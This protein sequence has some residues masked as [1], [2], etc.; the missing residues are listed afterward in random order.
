MK[1]T[2]YILFLLYTQ[3][4]QAQ[5]A[6]SIIGNWSGWYEE[7]QKNYDIRLNVEKFNGIFY[8]GIITL[9]YNDKQ[10]KFSIEG[11]IE[12]NT[13]KVTERNIISQYAPEYVSN[14]QWC[15]A[16]YEF[17][18]SDLED[19]FQLEGIAKMPEV[20]IAYIKGVKV[21]DSPKCTYFEEGIIRLQRKNPNYQGE[22]YLEKE[23]ERIVYIRKKPSN[24]IDAILGEFVRQPEDYKKVV[25]GGTT[26]TYRDGEPV[27]TSN[28]NPEITTKNEKIDLAENQGREVVEAKTI[29]SNSGTARIQVWDDRTVD[30]DIISIYHNGKL[31][32]E[33]IYLL[34]EKKK[35]FVT[36]ERGKNVIVM[37]AVNLGETPPNSAAMSVNTGDKQYSMVLTSDTKKSE[38][39]VIYYYP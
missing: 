32:E 39:V 16:D 20:N 33:N 6:Q 4:I 25:V 26:P 24:G 34:K 18:F 7:G 38:S 19:R 21:Y 15:K 23:K 8:E 36:L 27:T 35:L 5:N 29:E 2:F 37:H 11:Y 9:I 10:A 13:F 1:N 17:I 31:V 30:G 22:V 12:K 14:P 3:F 28:P